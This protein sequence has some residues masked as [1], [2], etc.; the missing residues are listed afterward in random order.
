[1]VVLLGSFCLAVSDMSGNFPSDTIQDK[2]GNL[3]LKPF[4]WMSLMTL[5]F[6]VWLLHSIEAT[7]MAETA[8][9]ALFLATLFLET[10]TD[11]PSMV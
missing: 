8:A 1:M 7:V 2:D 11:L 10:I 6:P 9:V 5:G 3:S 4:N